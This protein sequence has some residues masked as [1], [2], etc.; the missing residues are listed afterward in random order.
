MKAK[1]KESEEESDRPEKG[2]TPRQT[3]FPDARYRETLT[4]RPTAKSGS[5]KAAKARVRFDP[6]LPDPRPPSPVLARRYSAEPPREGRRIVFEGFLGRVGCFI[7]AH[8]YI[9]RKGGA[10]SGLISTLLTLSSGKQQAG[11][12]G[13][14]LSLARG[15]L[16]GFGRRYRA[17]G[18]SNLKTLENLGKLRTKPDKTSRI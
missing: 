16:R 17:K 11:R 7:R 4:E 8:L 12:Q 1:R 15:V 9:E 10:F 13:A 3:E 2:G 6:P 5:G 18:P 14:F